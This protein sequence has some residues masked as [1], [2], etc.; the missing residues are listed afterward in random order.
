MNINLLITRLA[1]CDLHIT[2]IWTTTR[3][4]QNLIRFRKCARQTEANH[5][6]LCILWASDHIATSGSDDWRDECAVVDAKNEKFTFELCRLYS[7]R[8][9]MWRYCGR[10]SFVFSLNLAE[11]KT[12]KRYFVCGSKLVPCISLSHS[13]I[14]TDRQTYSNPFG[15][16]LTRLFCFVFLHFFLSY[17]ANEFNLRSIVWSCCRLFA[18]TI[19]HTHTAKWMW[20]VDDRHDRRYRTERKSA[21]VSEWVREEETKK[22]HHGAPRWHWCSIKSLCFFI[23]SIFFIVAAAVTIVDVVLVMLISGLFFFS[24]RNEGKICALTNAFA[25]AAHLKSNP[26]PWFRQN[27]NWTETATTRE[28]K[29]STENQYTYVYAIIIM[30]AS[31]DNCVRSA[32]MMGHLPTAHYNYE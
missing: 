4:M 16:G 13:W 8:C 31:I 3:L 26:T 15:D 9:V 12:M 22:K 1:E 24:W 23:E 32:T 17:S 30:V 21:W 5:H 18:T 14:C 19:T 28:E 2:G 27:A 20:T 25:F 7:H 11:L 10:N 29:N 6:D